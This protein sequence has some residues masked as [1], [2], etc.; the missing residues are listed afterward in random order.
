MFFLFVWFNDKLIIILSEK[1]FFC[2][3]VFVLM[4]NVR[5]RGKK[6]WKFFI[7]MYCENEIVKIVKC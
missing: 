3:G 7:L 5:E 4:M 2:R 6:G 1:E